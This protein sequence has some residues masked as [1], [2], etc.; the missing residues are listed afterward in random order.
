M[1]KFL[2][3]VVVKCNM[4]KKDYSRT[5]GEFFNPLVYVHG[6]CCTCN[7]E[8]LKHLLKKKICILTNEFTQGR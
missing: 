4:C 7:G 5:C 8:I 6:C 1:I 2:K 3:P